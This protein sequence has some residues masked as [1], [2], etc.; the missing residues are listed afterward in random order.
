MN[1]TQAAQAFFLATFVILAACAAASWAARR[2]GQP[3]VVAQ[4]ITGVLLGPSIL[5]LLWPHSQSALFPAGIR[6]LLYTLGQFGLVAFMFQAGYEFKTRRP[7]GAVRSAAF[8]SSI[9]SAVPLALGAAVTLWLGH[10]A[11]VFQTGRSALVSAAFVG[12]TLTVTAFPM[13]ANIVHTRGYSRLR[14]GSLALACGAIDDVVAWLLLAAVTAAAA[15]KSRPILIAV[16]GCQL[17]RRRA[18]PWLAAAADRR[19]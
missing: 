18:V 17:G 15:G 19:G 2:V 16:V 12:V 6:P 5:G 4:M 7:E 8:V 1:P 13:L 9:G 14:F 3:E 11:G 10:W